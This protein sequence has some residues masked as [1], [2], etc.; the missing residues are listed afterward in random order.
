M[1]DLCSPIPRVIRGLC[2]PRMGNV[3]V[4]LG[5]RVETLYTTNYTNSLAAL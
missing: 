4:T 3:V 2:C 5:C 1:G